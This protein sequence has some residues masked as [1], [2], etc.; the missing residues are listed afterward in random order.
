MLSLLRCGVEHFIKQ[1]K[2]QF[3]YLICVLDTFNALNSLR[4]TQDIQNIQNIY[5]I[6]K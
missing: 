5:K 3:G 2:I 6:S 1:A 4:T